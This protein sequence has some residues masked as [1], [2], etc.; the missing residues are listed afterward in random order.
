MVLGKEVRLRNAYVIK[1]QRVEKDEQGNVTTIFCEYDADTLGKDPADGRKVK[2]VI[3]WVSAEYAVA[4]EIRL[5][6]SLFSVPN[7]AAEED[8]AACI[9]TNS[10]TVK[11]GWVEPSL[12]KVDVNS[13]EIH[14]YQFE[15][16]GY[17]CFD[18][19][20]TADKLVFN[21]TVGLRDTW[22]KIGD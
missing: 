14:A 12:A 13:S 19:D 21:R 9:N 6:D 18:K 7:P 5:Y 20:S 17:F 4:A 2:G 16:T 15:R 22:A 1:A 3:H 8:F 10:L 11:N